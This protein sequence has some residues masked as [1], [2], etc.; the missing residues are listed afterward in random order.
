MAS[1]NFFVY[2]DEDVVVDIGLFWQLTWTDVNVKVASID[3]KIRN[4][5]LQFVS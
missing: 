4:M 1:L 2:P 5:W 3:Y